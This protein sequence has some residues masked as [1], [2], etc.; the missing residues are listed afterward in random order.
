MEP[1][2]KPT[3]I[4][5]ALERIRARSLPPVSQSHLEPSTSSKFVRQAPPGVPQE[6]FL[7]QVKPE[8]LDDIRDA[9][10]RGKFPVFIHGPVGC[11]KTCAAACI[12][13]TWK[14]SENRAGTVRWRRCDT[15]LDEILK[16]R[17][18]DG[19]TVET[20]G[21]DLVRMTESG[22]FTMFGAA[23]LAVLDDI[24]TS[25]LNEER[26][27]ALLR[28]LDSRVGKPTI[29]TSNK[30]PSEL[31]DVYDYRVISRVSAGMVIFVSG[32][33][34]RVANSEERFR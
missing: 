4:S 25:K 18:S 7:E 19:V 8:L 28:L 2:D 34:R 24:G 9:F 27:P 14:V 20:P 31:S 6:I 10:A 12:Y 23:D 17:F 26:Y 11:G 30:G 5:E 15:L 22:L 29:I 32:D 21:G 16:A 1:T 3:S 33:D 13:R